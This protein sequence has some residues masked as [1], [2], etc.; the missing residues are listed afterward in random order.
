MS[1]IRFDIVKKS[2]EG[3]DREYVSL[4]HEEI[5]NGKSILCNKENFINRL[6]KSVLLKRIESGY[7]YGELMNSLDHSGLYD[8]EII[9]NNASHLINDFSIHKDY[10]EFEYELLDTSVS[11]LIGDSKILPIMRAITHEVASYEGV[12][13]HKVN[14]IFTID[15]LY[16]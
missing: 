12:E 15:L 6:Q 16:Q 1:S 3:E 4:I 5:S 14:E 8:L 9:L 10:I 11:H 2:L 13:L 7:C